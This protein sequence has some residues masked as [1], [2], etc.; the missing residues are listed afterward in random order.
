MAD[1]A[2]ALALRHQADRDQAVG[3][4]LELI[5]GACSAISVVRSLQ[6][7]CSLDLDGLQRTLDELHKCRLRAILEDQAFRRTMRRMGADVR[8]GQVASR[9]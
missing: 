4:A 7:L 6:S 8:P 5:D 1:S 3:R 2:T 9:D